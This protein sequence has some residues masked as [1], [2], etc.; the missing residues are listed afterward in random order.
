MLMKVSIVGFGRFGQTLYRLLKDDFNIT[1]YTPNP[2]RYKHI[3]LT[4][5]TYIAKSIKEIYNS[6]VIFYAVPI[7]TFEEVIKEHK[8][9]FNN[10]LLIDVL[11][12]K[13][14]PKNIFE[15]Y[16]KD[17]N[18]RALL[19]H[20]MFGPDSSKNGFEGLSIVIDRCY[21]KKEEYSFW[22]NYLLDKKLRVVEM[23]AQQHDKLA[24]TS[25]GITHFIGR[26][27]EEYDFK[28]TPIDTLGAK[29]LLEVMEQTCNDTWELFMNLQNYN[30][31]TRKMR[32]DFGKV[33]DKVYNRLLPRK[34]HKGVT[35]FGIQGG[36]GSFNE[37]AILKYIRDH[38][39][40]NPRIKY[41][42]TSE[43]VL[44]NLHKGNIDFGLFA[45]QNSLGGVVGESVQAMA[46]YKFHIVK[47]FDIPIRHF[48]MTRKDANFKIIDT[49][50]AHPQV[51]AQCKHTL[52]KKYKNL[53]LIS[54]KG[55]L[56]D[57]AMAAKALAKGKLSSNY[58]ILGP[59]TLAAIYDFEIVDNDLQDDKTNNTAFL[60]VKR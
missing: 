18:T 14:H 13:I 33:Y 54:G 43:K 42:Y 12:V 9:Y 15:K 5:Q 51:L 20:P 39:I 27:L 47:E 31:Y 10:H 41:L 3:A 50:I 2:K 36:V 8:K 6:E 1:L 16:L 11:S 17:T 38:N 35:V 4:K 23:S 19:T 22:K 32:L 29:K 7:S 30:P 56:V 40:K 46:K 55:D 37:Q 25:Q 57:T 34:I 52:K 26:L 59:Q 60:L 45:I 58:A 49:I 24:A 48:L 21:A 44:N 53:S 28:E